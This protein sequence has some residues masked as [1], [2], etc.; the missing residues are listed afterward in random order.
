MKIIDS[1]LFIEFTEMEA[2]NVPR[3]TI[4]SWDNIKDPGDRRKILISYESLKFK[5]QELIIK[6]FGDPY[7]YFRNLSIK[8]YL[9]VDAKAVDFYSNYRT[10]DG[11]TLPSEKIK[12]YTTCANWTLRMRILYTWNRNRKRPCTTIWKARTIRLMIT[13]I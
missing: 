5:Y 9:R 12:Q 2:C 8:K 1:I 13:T 11:D 6:R 3:R 4:L 7:L 10:T